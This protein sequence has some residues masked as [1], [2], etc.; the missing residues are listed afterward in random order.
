MGE[1]QTVEDPIS[2]VTEIFLELKDTS[3]L[4]VDLA[5]SSL[6]YN[7]KELA[8]EVEHLG[9]RIDDLSADLRRFAVEKIS[10]RSTDATLMLLRMCNY[11]NSIADAALSIVDVVMR[12]IEPHQILKQSIQES[13][14]AI[15]RVELLK[16]S[17]LVNKE[18]KEIRLATE[19]G[20]WVIAIKRASRWICG[21][22][23][24]EELRNRDLLFVRGPDEGM[25]KLKGL[26]S[27]KLRKIG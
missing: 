25:K 20:M 19:T 23:E 27:G 17:V 5:Y 7:D 10:S 15:F 18:L 8:A 16:R 4:M 13:D 2:S 11:V 3:E 22:G 21:P 14:T 12:D 1:I 6:L 9:E 26:A 24:D